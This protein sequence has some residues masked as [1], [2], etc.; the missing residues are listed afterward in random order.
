[1][2]RLLAAVALALL[3]SSGASMEDAG[4]MQ[5]VHPPVN[6]VLAPDEQHSIELVLQVNC[7]GAARARLLQLYSATGNGTAGNMQWQVQLEEDADD[8]FQVAW[9]M[10]AADASTLTA[11]EHWHCSGWRQWQVVVHR[12]NGEREHAL[13]RV[14]ASLLED[15]LEMIE[16][17]AE[18]RGAAPSFVQV[19]AMVSP[20]Y[21]PPAGFDGPEPVICRPS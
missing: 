6:Y 2:C 11:Y 19:G 15:A 1:M 12:E 16:A 7:P 20:Q 17:A 8:M 10:L 9:Q 4:C 13:I 18:Q 5:V 21:H 3:C 14:R